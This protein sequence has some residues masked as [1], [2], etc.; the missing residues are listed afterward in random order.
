MTCFVS[1]VLLLFLYVYGAFLNTVFY[2]MP[3]RR[4]NLN[5][6]TVSSFLI[7]TPSSVYYYHRAVTYVCA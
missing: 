6:N 2:E 3:Q 5:I 1:V 7:K 4:F